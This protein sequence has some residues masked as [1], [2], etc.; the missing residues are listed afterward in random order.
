[1]S[2]NLD[3]FNCG[4]TPKEPVEVG[5][6]EAC[7]GVIYNYELMKCGLCDAR[8][9]GGCS[10]EC[11]G[12]GMLGCKSCLKENDEGLL[13]CEEC[14]PKEVEQQVTLVGMVRAATEKLS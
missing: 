12:C 7:S 1:M 10:E 14:N 11:D 8:I 2:T 4:V 13:L 9:H 6:C 3:R 5:C